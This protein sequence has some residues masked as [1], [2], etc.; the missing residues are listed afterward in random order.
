MS[1]ADDLANIRQASTGGPDFTVKAWP[2]RADVETAAGWRLIEWGRREGYDVSDDVAAIEAEARHLER[3]ALRE[4][5]AGL[6]LDPQ[7]SAHYG[8]GYRMAIGAVLALLSEE[9]NR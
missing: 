9:E 1:R 2:T 4:K 3:A 6:T 8:R 7:Y 5:V